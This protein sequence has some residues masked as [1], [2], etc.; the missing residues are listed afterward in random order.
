MTNAERLTQQI[1][2]QEEDKAKVKAEIDA[3]VAAQKAQKEVAAQQV[4]DNK[5]KERTDAE[6]K[7]TAYN[8]RLQQTKRIINPITNR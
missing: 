6:T 2:A 3:R 4:K 5:A 1:K 8:A 7:Q